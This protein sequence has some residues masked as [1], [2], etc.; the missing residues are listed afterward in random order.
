M[1]NMDEDSNP[2]SVPLPIS[3]N[4]R[5]ASDVKLID[6]NCIVQPGFTD[7]YEDCEQNSGV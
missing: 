2:T 7:R 4:E 6:G 5:E 3:P 1:E